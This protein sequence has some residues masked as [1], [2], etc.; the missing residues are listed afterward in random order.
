MGDK[1]FGVSFTDDV[2]LDRYALHLEAEAQSS[3]TQFYSEKLG[4]AKA[5]KDTAEHRVKF[6]EAEKGL[7]YR[8]NPPPDVKI[9]DAVIASLIATN[10]E[11]VAAQKE[12]LEAKRN[13]YTYDSAVTALDHKSSML[14]IL[15]QLFSS[16]YYTIS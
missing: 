3:L 4:E 8:A 15:T 12:L 14:K 1:Q 2:A 16:G 13:V 7:W 11:V 6:L 9:T 5:E 10:D